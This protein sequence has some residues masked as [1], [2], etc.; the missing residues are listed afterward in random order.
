MLKFTSS[1]TIDLILSDACK[2][3][4]LDFQPL[5]RGLPRG[6]TN[7]RDFGQG[8]FRSE[9]EPFLP[10]DQL[11]KRIMDVG[12]GSGLYDISL[13][14]HYA[15]NENLHIYLFDR[16]QSKDKRNMQKGRVFGY[17]N[18]SSEFDFYASLECAK[19]ALVLNGAR[20]GNVHTIEASKDNMNYLE[21]NSFDFIFSLMSWGFHYPIN[22]Y[23][24]EA[25]RLLRIGG[26]LLLHSRL[27][28]AKPL[29]ELGFSCTKIDARK[30]STL[31]CTKKN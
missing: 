22:T 29:E 2:R 1:K 18:S 17:H 9:I 3:I 28:D 13:L 6:A 10:S 12:C 21:P 16:T 23:S 26:V 19:E 14:E 25:Y 27:R 5:Q 24:A 30:A 20:E 11:P 4:V 31:V 8:T 7:L 15:F